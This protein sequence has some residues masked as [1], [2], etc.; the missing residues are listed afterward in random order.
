MDG[1]RGERCFFRRFPDD[2]IAADQGQRGI[3]G[4]DGDREVER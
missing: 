2:G 1:Q 4:P 3:P